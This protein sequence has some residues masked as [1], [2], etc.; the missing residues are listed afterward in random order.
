MKTLLTKNN[1]L[2]KLKE[3]YMQRVLQRILIVIISLLITTSSLL[4]YPDLIVTSSQQLPP[5][6]HN[7][8]YII[9]TSNG[10]LS[11]NNATINCSTL[12]VD[13][14]MEVEWGTITCNGS[15]TIGGEVHTNNAT[16]NCSGLTITN[17]GLLQAYDFLTITCTS[18]TLN[19]RLE[20]NGLRFRCS[21]SATI[22]A[23]GYLWLGDI[24]SDL[25]FSSGLTVVGQIISNGK[26]G[27]LSSRTKFWLGGNGLVIDGHTQFI[28]TDFY[29][30][31]PYFNSITINGGGG[32]FSWCQIISG[33]DYGISINGGMLAMGGT[34][35]VSNHVGLN[36]TNYS[37]G[38]IY[39][40]NVF[41]NRD[42]DIKGVASA[43]I[44]ASGDMG[45]YNSFR[46]Y[47]YHIYSEYSGIITAL[48][49]YWLGGAKISKYN[50]L[51]NNVDASNPLFTDPNPYYSR[52]ENDN[53]L[54]IESG[55]FLKKSVIKNDKPIEKV[56][57]IEELDE[58]TKLLY[59]KKYDEALPELHKLVDKYKDG[60][61]GKRALAFIEYI[62]SETERDK[63][64]LPMLEQY[65]NGKSK[66]AQFAHY[67]KV[68]Q[69]FKL[70]E[71]DKAI[72]IMKTTEFSEEDADLRQARLYDLGIAYY[73]LLGKKA[74]AYN[75]FDELVKTYPDCPLAEVA[76]TVYRITKDGYEK[77]T[78]SEDEEV[79]T[80][81]ETKLFA[82]YPNPFNP[83]TVIKYQLADAAQISLKVYDVM[84]REVATLVNTYQNKG[85]YEVTFNAN[86]LASGIYFYKLNAGGKQFINK[87]LLMK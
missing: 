75:Y 2:I 36:F 67:R 52:G 23:S 12:L 13:G 32:S 64:I 28:H 30:I 74:E 49:N 60:F 7:Y 38:F 50:N 18:F 10:D 41:E 16:L 51:Y 70:Q 55:I 87:M 31:S 83:T 44:N 34:K 77:P 37:L 5:G 24:Y 45:G 6:V 17:N 80:V 35:V 20:G 57:G 33:G 84:G 19:G 46:G 29:P 85:S 27:A 26:D 42:Y 15:A 66:V 25:V 47:G 81:T 73:D 68:Y 62:L 43:G 79:V 8:N 86:G 1:F 11:V 56:P 9:V 39:Q 22:T 54:E 48:H 65:S 63:E 3:F 72:E 21:G 76:N 78:E 40:K 53:K 82:N 61:V 69:Y 4:S 14:W 58:A 59:S 71:Y